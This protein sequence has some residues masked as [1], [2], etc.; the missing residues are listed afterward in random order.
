[1][2]FTTN[3]FLYLFFPLALI[4]FYLFPPRLR[5][6]PLLF[7]SIFFYAW[8]EPLL[9][10]LILASALINF[11]VGK[12]LEKHKRNKPVLIVGILH[13]HTLSCGLIL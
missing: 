4:L 6:F 9:V 7:L 10:L 2:V 13:I 8:G 12:V 5:A 11:R 1:M 3:I